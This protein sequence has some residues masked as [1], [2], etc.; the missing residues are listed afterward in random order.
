MNT[1][2]HFGQA[3]GGFQRPALQARAVRTADGSTSITM[4]AHDN[5]RLVAP[6]LDEV[7]LSCEIVR[8]S[9]Y[10]HDPAAH[11]HFNGSRRCT[12][13]TSRRCTQ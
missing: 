10:D 12:P 2:T 6:S 11:A 3:C 8:P 1:T 7:A 5:S 4:A 13:T 9:D